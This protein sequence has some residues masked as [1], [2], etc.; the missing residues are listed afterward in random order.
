MAAGKSFNDPIVPNLDN[1]AMAMNRR[2]EFII[3]PN[4]E[5]IEEIIEE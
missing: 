5:S 4:L 2:V 1:R 3:I